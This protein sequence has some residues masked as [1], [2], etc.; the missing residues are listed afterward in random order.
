LEAPTEEAVTPKTA[1]FFH[2]LNGAHFCAVHH[3]L[4]HR[5]VM[6]L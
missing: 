5:I 3:I 1:S 6:Q 2:M 4:R